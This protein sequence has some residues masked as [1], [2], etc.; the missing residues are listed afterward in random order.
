MGDPMQS[1]PPSMPRPNVEYYLVPRDRRG[2]LTEFGQGITSAV[3]PGGFTL[4]LTDAPLTESDSS[5]LDELDEALKIPNVR[6]PSPN[7]FMVLRVE[8]E[9]PSS[10]GLV[11]CQ[12][13]CGGSFSCGGGGGGH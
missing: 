13:M 5:V 3:A 11:G 10:V 4:T 1:T 2:D 7:P 8:I 6:L 12:C 9:D